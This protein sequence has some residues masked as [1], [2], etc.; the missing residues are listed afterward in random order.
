MADHGEAAQDRVPALDQVV[1]RDR[2]GRG[3]CRCRPE[4]RPSIS[5]REYAFSAWSWPTADTLD[6]CP[7]PS[8][9]CAPV[10]ACAGCTRSRPPSRWPWCCCSPVPR[11]SCSPT[12]SCATPCRRPR[13]NRP[14]WSQRVE[15][16]FEDD[17]EK[18]ADDAT[19]KRGDL[20]QVVRDY[21]PDG[22]SDID[23]IGASNP[24]WSVGPMSSLMPAPGEVEVD[25]SEWVTYRD[26]IEEDDPEVTEEVL[27]VAY[28]ASVKGATSSSTPPSR[29]S[30]CTTPSRPCSA[31]RWSGSRCWC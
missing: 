4:G 13:C 20:V 11:S 26:G 17:V 2:S 27:A 5:S 24:L 14:R 31:W 10:G 3:H 22:P 23:V 1:S 16:N 9:G 12:A 15:A 28:G 19:A 6:T 25:R 21:D 8:A 18:N 7:A 30:R 29:W